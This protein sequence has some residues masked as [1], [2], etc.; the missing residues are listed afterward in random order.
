MRL[1]FNGLQILVLCDGERFHDEAV[2]VVV[3]ACGVQEPAC[4][5]KASD[6][7]AA[8]PDNQLPGIGVHPVGYWSKSHFMLSIS[9]V[10]LMLPEITRL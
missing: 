3:A 5:Y 8:F 4:G 6:R 2:R 10:W 7:Q 1:S 9:T